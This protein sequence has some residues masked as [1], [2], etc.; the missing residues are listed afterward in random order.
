M[1]LSQVKV[2]G[3]PG[4]ENTGWLLIH[5][6]ISLVQSGDPLQAADFLAALET[7]N[8]AGNIKKD[9]PLGS[10]LPFT[11]VNGHTKR[12]D[13]S[14]KTAAYGIFTADPG[15]IRKLA[16]INRMFYETDRIE[17][18]RRLD[19]FRWISFVELPGSSKLA[20]FE[21]IAA[22]L[23]RPFRQNRKTNIT[24]W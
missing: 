20:Q 5:P 15:F 21:Q 13:P 8:P 6:H 16:K 22:P 7:I 9:T 18:G 4:L 14:K 11:K 12:V 17:V 23:L 19:L 3:L 2:R 1:E 10:Y 24:T